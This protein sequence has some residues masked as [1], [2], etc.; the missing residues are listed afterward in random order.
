MASYSSWHR[1]SWPQASKTRRPRNANLDAHVP[2]KDDVREEHCRDLAL[3]VGGDCAYSHSWVPCLLNTM[4]ND[5]GAALLLPGCIHFPLR[6]SGKSF[7]CRAISVE[8]AKGIS[9][10][11]LMTFPWRHCIRHG[12]QTGCSMLDDKELAALPTRGPHRPAKA[13]A[14]VAGWRGQTKTPTPKA[15]AT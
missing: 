15:I 9:V 13:P 1:S 3:R 10:V 8:P 2:S 14:P 5:L 6:I 12:A 4:P 11:M 7:Q